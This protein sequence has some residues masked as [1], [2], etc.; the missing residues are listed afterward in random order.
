MT[1]IKSRKIIQLDHPFS[2]NESFLKKYVA[3]LS[4]KIKQNCNGNITK[5]IE[6]FFKNGFHK[7]Y[8]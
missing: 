2:L 7:T 3:T 1:S 6:V 5:T 8:Q 4:E